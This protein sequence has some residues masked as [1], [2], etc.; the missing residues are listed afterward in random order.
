MFRD[1]TQI[2]LQDTQ[3]AFEKDAT[4]YGYYSYKPTV[5]GAKV[6]LYYN[7]EASPSQT[8]TFTVK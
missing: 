4:Y 3:T 5:K 1:G 2:Q 6:E 7:G 8:L